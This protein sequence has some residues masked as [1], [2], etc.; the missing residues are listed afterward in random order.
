[1]VPRKKRATTGAKCG[2]NSDTILI[3]SDYSNLE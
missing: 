3:L 2:M 1:M